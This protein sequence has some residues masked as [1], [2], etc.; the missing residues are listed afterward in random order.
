M[1]LDPVKRRFGYGVA[2]LAL[3]TPAG[4]RSLSV[5]ARTATGREAIFAAMPT[6]LCTAIALLLALTVQ[7]ESSNSLDSQPLAR[8]TQNFAPQIEIEL[9]SSA[10]LAAPEEVHLS[11][12]IAKPR[13]AP[14]T[15]PAPHTHPEPSNP[16]PAT[17]KREP[18][19]DP[20]SVAMR[21]VDSPSTNIKKPD[22]SVDYSHASLRPRLRATNFG[23]DQP[24]QIASALGVLKPPSASTRN[25]LSAIEAGASRRPNA[26]AG[27]TRAPA[28]AGLNRS[29]NGRKYLAARASY[30][31]I[32]PSAPQID[33]IPA[34]S[35]A[36]MASA[37]AIAREVRDELG[38]ATYRSN[39]REVPLA[40]L[41][42][43]SP[44]GRQDLLKKRILLAA[45]FEREC[46]HQDGSYRFIET[47]NLGAFLMWS[48]PNPDRSAGQPRTLD[49]CDVLERALRCLDG[50]PIE[51][52]IAQ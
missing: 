43:C 29:D 1:I 13:S 20:T 19:F 49:V 17:P 3:S 31:S 26:K 51:E 8:A 18:R 5:V 28:M 30:R 50:S 48:R 35:A 41:P 39:W 14:T 6:L 27:Q 11:V 21:R 10:A 15:L 36:G 25:A 32:G 37:N 38:Q 16:E 4:G 34:V 12:A 52:S 33:R 7:L 42:D 45:P 47:R 9:W 23:T 2:R 44:P 24:E 40:E 22:P 46:S